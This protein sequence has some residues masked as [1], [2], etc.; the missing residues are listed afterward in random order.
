MQRGDLAPDFFAD[1]Q[2]GANGVAQETMPAKQVF[3][4]AREYAALRLADDETEVLQQA[5]DLVLEIALDLHQLGPAVQHRP[6]LMTRHALDPNLPVP[7]GLHDPRQ[8][9]GVVAV[10]LV[11]LHRQCRL[12]MA[13]INADY[14]QAERPELMPEPGRG[15]SRLE[16]D[17]YR[18]WRIGLNNPCNRLRFRDHC[19]FKKHLAAAIDHANR[20]LLE[21][22]IHSN[23][24]FHSCSPD[25]SLHADR[26]MP[27][28]ARLRGAPPSFDQAV[29]N[30]RVTPCVKTRLC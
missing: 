3:D 2:K 27:V 21:R 6:N 9:D 11:D 20:G 5:P 22:H 24:A 16:A 15:R 19:A 17:T 7:T 28:I 18:L 12:G 10:T 1:I 4:P 30:P 25:L 26:P 29:P 13:G 8:A 23:I 14:W